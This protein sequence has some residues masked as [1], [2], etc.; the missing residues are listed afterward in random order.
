MIQKN[1]YD[2][3]DCS[4]DFLTIPDSLITFSRDVVFQTWQILE[5]QL[6]Q[7]DP[8]KD[9]EMYQALDSRAA[10]LFEAWLSFRNAGRR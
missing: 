2:Y 5:R 9:P 7:V 8:V 4:S 3:F 1:I 6:N 10:T